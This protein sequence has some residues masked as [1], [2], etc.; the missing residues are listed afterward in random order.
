[1]CSER[2]RFACADLPG[3]QQD[4]DVMTDARHGADRA[5]ACDG[6]G[7]WALQR[8]LPASGG[9]LGWAS[10]VVASVGGAVGVGGPPPQATGR[11][12]GGH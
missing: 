1:M 8:A 2:A 5:R 9:E 4:A 10:R 11:P 7:Q 6:T 12:G 3:A